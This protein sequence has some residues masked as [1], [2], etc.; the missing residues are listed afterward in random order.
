MLVSLDKDCHNHPMRENATQDSIDA[1]RLD[2]SR[3]LDPGRKS[4]FGQFMTPTAIAAFMASLFSATSKT[5]HLLDAGAG[6]GSLTNAF[7]TRFQDSTA[8]VQA[9]EM[10]PVLKMVLADTLASHRRAGLAST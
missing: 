7:L 6:V 2:A 8:S 9:W 10:R 4:E 5:I 1:V 3:P